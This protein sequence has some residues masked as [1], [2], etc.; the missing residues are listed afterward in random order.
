MKRP[1]R[2][3]DQPHLKDGVWLQAEMLQRAQAEFDGC[4]ERVNSWDAFMAAL[5]RKH[6]CLAPW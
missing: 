6:M 1:H 4:I 2:L 5:E 3:L